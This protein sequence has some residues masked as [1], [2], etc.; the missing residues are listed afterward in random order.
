MDYRLLVIVSRLLLACGRYRASMR[1]WCAALLCAASMRA[2]RLAIAAPPALHSSRSP[3]GKSRA[4]ACVARR[5][6]R[7]IRT[8]L[9]APVLQLYV[10]MRRHHV[11]VAIASVLAGIAV[12]GSAHAATPT[13]SVIDASPGAAST[14]A[15]APLTFGGVTYFVGTMGGG[16]GLW[17]T[18]GTA[19]G[20]STVKMLT[21]TAPTLARLA[22]V[23]SG[24]VIVTATASSSTDTVY[25][26]D[27]S[28]AGTLP[29]LTL[30]T[31]PPP[32]P[33][34]LTLL[35]ITAARAYFTRGSAELIITDGTAAG[36]KVLPSV[37]I[38]SHAAAGNYLWMRD[39]GGRVNRIADGNVESFDAQ[40]SGGG[41]LRACGNA[42]F[43]SRFTPSPNALFA[44][45]GGAATQL[46]PL[47]N[48][49]STRLEGCVGNKL[50]F[51]QNTAANGCEPWIS[52]GTAVGTKLLKDVRPG[53]GG[54]TLCFRPL[55][56][57]YTST[58]PVFPLGNFT[59]FAAHEVDDTTWSVWGTDGTEAG[60]RKLS[61]ADGS[62][63]RKLGT[64]GSR[65]YL[66]TGTS[67]LSILWV[68]GTSTGTIALGGVPIPGGAGTAE[69]PFEIASATIG[70]KV[71]STTAGS[72]GVEPW[73]LD[74]PD[75]LSAP[76][77][78]APDGGGSSGSSG[79]SSSGSS[80]AGTD[81]AAPPNAES[82]SGCAAAPRRAASAGPG[83][84]FALACTLVGLR[85]R[86]RTARRGG[87]PTS[88]IAG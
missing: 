85:R 14:E 23:P 39:G 43:F 3:I 42:V 28:A 8:L 53:A 51:F 63:L 52:D 20:T 80:G 55:A 70:S 76:D 77:A 31:L 58:N 78:G 13:V 24:F 65:M 37:G 88:P 69:P 68:D 57:V 38:G 6:E 81:G 40:V 79:A 2:P 66:R 56:P 32:N 18:D 22:P 30:P 87:G 17:R 33:S 48:S 50:L 61:A 10:A 67:P 34:G 75:A 16:W 84:L 59:V 15:R 44:T 4:R 36:T 72:F 54:S 26:S 21:A 41:E 74:D 73:V 12:A 47:G 46:V 71:I 11:P 83:A 49:L 45:T 19:A 82:S 86:G 60:T 62:S 35:G 29:L 27:G 5:E 9:W 1:T 25:K 64:A 7:G